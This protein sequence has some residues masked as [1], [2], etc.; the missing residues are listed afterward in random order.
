MICCFIVL[1][2]LYWWWWRGNQLIQK[3]SLKLFCVA[4]A[5]GISSL[6]AM[7]F[8]LDPIW[9]QTELTGGDIPHLNA[10]CQAQAVSMEFV[11]LFSSIT[12]FIVLEMYNL[13]LSK[14]LNKFICCKKH[15]Y[16]VVSHNSVGSEEPSLSISID[17]DNKCKSISVGLIWVIICIITCFIAVFGYNIGY[18]YVGQYKEDVVN[19]TYGWYGCYCESAF[20]CYVLWGGP[21]IILEIYF[22]IT[23]LRAFNLTVH[24]S[25]VDQARVVAYVVIRSIIVKFIYFCLINLC[26]I[27]FLSI[28]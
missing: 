6:G 7:T 24:R 22:V 11:Y 21:H 2:T 25:M 15:N 28:F 27:T 12:P 10:V 9:W 14:I 4:G 13:G 20:A 1:A 16:D 19:N 17:G 18:G 8:V 3:Y 5:S 23:A 26:Q